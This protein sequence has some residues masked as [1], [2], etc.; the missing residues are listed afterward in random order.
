ML[1]F[2]IALIVY[3]SQPARGYIRQERNT[4]TTITIQLVAT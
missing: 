1:I 4:T 3:C 2:L